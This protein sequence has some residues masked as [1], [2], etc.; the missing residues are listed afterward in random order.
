MGIFSR[1]TPAAAA[2]ASSGQ[3]SRPEQLFAV[4]TEGL[5]KARAS[6]AD[7]VVISVGDAPRDEALLN[8]LSGFVGDKQVAKETAYYDYETLTD[9][10]RK[11]VDA[12][13]PHQVIALVL[14]S[15]TNKNEFPGPYD[16]LRTYHED[17]VEVANRT[18]LHWFL[19]TLKESSLMRFGTTIDLYLGK[20]KLHQVAEELARQNPDFS[21]EVLAQNIEEGIQSCK[22]VTRR[23]IK[24]SGVHHALEWME[25]RER[26]EFERIMHLVRES[27][28]KT[29]K[30]G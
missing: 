10:E 13:K 9:G 15:S 8:R 29:N 19:P 7:R 3:N 24:A 6:W 14:K 5:Q 26:T 18:D 17:G 4:L 2:V 21:P 20:E 16:G 12:H 1:K 25:R 30:Q 22:E 28:G 23:L 27:V 11:S